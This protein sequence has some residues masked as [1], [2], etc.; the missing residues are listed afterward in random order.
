MKPLFFIVLVIIMNHDHY[1]FVPVDLTC[2]SFPFSSR[3]EQDANVHA[4]SVS[5]FS[6]FTYKTHVVPEN[7][8]MIH[9]VSTGMYPYIFFVSLL[10]FVP[11]YFIIFLGNVPC[12]WKGKDFSTVGKIAPTWICLIST[13]NK[14]DPCTTFVFLTRN[15]ADC[16]IV[17]FSLIFFSL[18]P[19]FLKKK[20]HQESC[21]KKRAWNA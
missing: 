14:T 9:W 4:R 3:I 19:P 11:G 8:K 2:S 21:T 6:S 12:W 1:F 15:N 5:F 16:K 13:K 20:T 17:T 18:H 10:S 7:K